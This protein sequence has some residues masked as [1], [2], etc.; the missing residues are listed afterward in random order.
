M[1]GRISRL[2]FYILSLALFLGV[3]IYA[4]RLY[5]ALGQMPLRAEHRLQVENEF[6]EFYSAR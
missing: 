4:V 1:L 2:L 5:D 6:Q 3:T